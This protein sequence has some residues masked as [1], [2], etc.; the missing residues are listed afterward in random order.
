VS[1]VAREADAYRNKAPSRLLAS[2]TISMNTSKDARSAITIAA[3][4]SSRDTRVPGSMSLQETQ[5]AIQTRLRPQK[6]HR[7]NPETP[8]LHS[9]IERTE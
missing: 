7:P 2:L 9:N 5:V 6:L 8:L 1:L 4:K 3:P